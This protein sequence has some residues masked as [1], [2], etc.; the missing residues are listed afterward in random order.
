MDLTQAPLPWRGYIH[1]GAQEMLLSPSAWDPT[2]PQLCALPWG[3]SQT[4]PHVKPPERPPG[5]AA[6]APPLREPRPIL[7][8]SEHQPEPEEGSK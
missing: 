4:R 2:D 6:L 7:G 3:Y 8:G 1:T 5:L